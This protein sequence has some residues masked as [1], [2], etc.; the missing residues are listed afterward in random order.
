L[1]ATEGRYEVFTANIG[2]SGPAFLSG[3]S[4]LVHHQRLKWGKPGDHEVIAGLFSG[5]IDA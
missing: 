2:H 5:A 3:G 1:V 4:Y